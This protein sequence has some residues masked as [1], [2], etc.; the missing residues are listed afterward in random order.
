MSAVDFKFLG[1]ALTARFSGGL[2]CGAVA[3]SRPK[4]FDRK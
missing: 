3:A 4:Y 1:M 2:G